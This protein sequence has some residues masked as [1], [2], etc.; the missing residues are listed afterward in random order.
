MTDHPTDD[1][2]NYPTDDELDQLVGY[3]PPTADTVARRSAALTDVEKVAAVRKLCW[4]TI[5]EDRS[6]YAVARF[7]AGILDIIGRQRDEGR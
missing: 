1:E 4:T 2:L 6:V 7:A 3:H 5:E